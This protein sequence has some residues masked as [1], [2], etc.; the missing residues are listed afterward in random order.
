MLKFIT[1]KTMELLPYLCAMESYDIDRDLQ[2]HCVRVSFMLDRKTRHAGTAGWQNVGTVDAC[3][4]ILCYR[5][6]WL[7]V[8]R[9]AT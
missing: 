9:L 5:T 2:A 4:Y 6:G 3:F 7:G 8:A 1:P